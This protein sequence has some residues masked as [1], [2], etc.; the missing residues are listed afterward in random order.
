MA[1]T[2]A[3][4]FTPT[5]IEEPGTNKV[6]LSAIACPLQ[7]V[8][9]SSDGATQQGWGGTSYT[10]AA[11]LD[12]QASPY[13]LS[14]GTAVA[15]SLS[16]GIAPACVYLAMRFSL[17]VVT[18]TQ[19]ICASGSFAVPHL[20]FRWNASAGKFQVVNAGAV[21]FTT[22]SASTTTATANQV[23]KL[24]FAVYEHASA[25]AYKILLD[26]EELFDVTGVNTS[27]GSGSLNGVIMAT[28]ANLTAQDFVVK[29][30]ASVYDDSDFVTD[31]G[32]VYR[33]ATMLPAASGTYT[34]ADEGSPKYGDIFKVTPS[35]GDEN[36]TTEVADW[37][38]I[39]ESVAKHKNFLNTYFL[40]MRG[41][42]VL[43]PAG[44]SDS[45]RWSWKYGAVPDEVQENI[46]ATINRLL[47]TQSTG[48]ATKFDFFHRIGGT[49][50][51]HPDNE[52]V[53]GNKIREPM[54]IGGDTVG[55]LSWLDTDS[56]DGSGGWT[57]AKLTNLEVGGMNSLAAPSVGLIY[58]MHAVMQ[59]LYLESEIVTSTIPEDLTAECQPCNDASQARHLDSFLEYDGENDDEG[60]E[61]T[62][63]LAP[64]ADWT[65]AG[66]SHTLTS[67]ALFSASD[68]GK[69]YRL[70]DPH[71]EYV[72][73]DVTAFGSS[74]SLTVTNRTAVGRTLQDNPTAEWALMVDSVAGLDHLEAELVYANADGM[75]L[76]PFTVT[77]GEVELGDHYAVVAVGLQIISDIE[78]LDFDIPGQGK[79]VSATQGAINQVFIHAEKSRSFKMG[80]P[81]DSPVDF[82]PYS[83]LSPAERADQPWLLV[84]RKDTF[85]VP[86]K[87]NHGKRVF[88]RHTDPLPLKIMSIE[89]KVD[90]GGKKAG[91]R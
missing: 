77:S 54:Q 49:N 73:L 66:L 39:G 5:F 61:I 14:A 15:Y 22:S 41:P 20:T 55:Y 91:G 26:G 89:P 70:G 85:N 25:G 21:N 67:S 65:T 80:D 88:I 81:N 30:G 12:G 72:V 3:E 51:D 45:A 83:L 1:L 34:M 2:L 13:A 23:Y 79:S 75:P 43:G 68:V 47:L 50:Y 18:G 24:E 44:G 37:Q 90:L 46:V 16:T 36:T 82:V 9:V 86:A 42:D 19:E 56:P 62:L 59:V 38:A 84:T 32:L 78:T 58:L 8:G 4:F 27:G 29:Y 11:G 6:V 60:D 76:G 28:N 63:T 57:I 87:W 52:D 48:S 31:G 35:T 71:G 17:S 33:V 53:G 10:L 7:M 40:R 69:A 74:S 64:G